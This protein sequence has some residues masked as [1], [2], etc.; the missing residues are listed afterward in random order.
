MVSP[1]PQP[2]AGIYPFRPKSWTTPAGAAMSYVDE[3]GT[4]EEAVLFLH[5]N[6][7]W[8]FHFR[9]A[10]QALAPRVRCVAPDHIGMGLSEKPLGYEYRLARR[11]DDIAGLVDH[12]GLRK[13]HLVVHDWGGAIGCG[14]AVRDPGRVGRIVLLNTAAFPSRR[15]AARIALC[16]IPILGEFIVRGLNGFAG[17]ATWMAMHARRLSA[18]ERQGYLW[19]YD[20]WNHR[21][22]V[23]RFVRDIPMERHHPSRPA[24]EHTASRLRT[25]SGHPILLGW[26][27]RDFCFDRHFLSRWREYFPQAEVQIYPDAGHYVL[28]DAGPAIVGRLRQFILPA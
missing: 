17:P 26:G 28:E 18:L 9:A 16:R 7:T 6:P 5:G 13:V 19:P 10:V 11:I 20:S 23:H 4:G 3:G 14:W 25:L 15:L 21:I 22:A 1:V 8:S 12:L 27:A 2:L 24:L